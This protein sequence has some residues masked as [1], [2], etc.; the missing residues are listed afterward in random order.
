MLRALALLAVLLLAG[1][2]R[3]G[4]QRAG[5]T[6][7]GTVAYH[8]EL[9]RLRAQVGLATDALRGL[10][11][12]PGDSPRSNQETFQTFA[13]EL[14]NLERAA[15]R[16]R[17]LHGKVDARAASFFGA[18]TR[19]TAALTD[20]ELKASAA[21]RRQ[22]LEANF[23]KLE[24]GQAGLEAAMARY[25]Q[26]LGNL[27]TY[28]EHDLTAAGLAQ[29]KRSIQAAFVNGALLQD[30]IEAQ[31]ALS[32]QAAHDMGPLKELAPLPKK[33]GPR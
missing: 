4:Y 3:T 28:L 33:P 21:A 5:A 30:Q 17:K 13:L 20:A 25:T 2:L 31:A 8:Q 32:R 12:N 18:W 26:E 7:D 16:A 1:C 24:E 29:A 27:R 9:V 23:Q 10:S 14:V 15:A 19:D 6:A 11:E 22:A